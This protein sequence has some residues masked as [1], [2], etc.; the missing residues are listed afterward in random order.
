MTNL[1]TTELILFCICLSALSF[2]LT[3]F[4]RRYA[5]DKRILDIPNNR[6]SHFVP[7]PR[8]GG[9]GFVCTFLGALVVLYLISVIPKEVLFALLGGGVLIAAVGWLDDN[10]GL[11]PVIRLFCHVVAA[12]W[13]VVWLGGYPSMTLGTETLSLS[14]AGGL[15][16][17][18]GTVWMINLYNFMDGIDGI[19]ATEA[20]TVSAI[21]GIILF[22][23]GNGGLAMVCMALAFS[24]VGFLIWNWPPARI[25]MGDVGSGFLGFVFACLAIASENSGALP[26]VV[27]VVLLGV[28]V[29]D[30]TV[31]LIRRFIN[32]EKLYEAHRTHVYQLAVQA[33]FSHKQVT[34]T[35]CLIN[36][37]LG[38][39]AAL[40]AK[41]PGWISPA[42]VLVVVLLTMA[43]VRLYRWFSATLEARE[44]LKV[45]SE[46]ILDE[47]AAST[48]K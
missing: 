29:V 6:S 27:W 35:V 2:G 40:L 44:E 4:V 31:T 34:V 30:A 24:V 36:I 11:T 23:T 25:F 19:A 13:G 41:W 22:V 38:L 26:L 47:A 28:F 37:G 9:L 43:E 45:V 7:T 46:N 32:K 12:V 48:E 15:L 17:V 39:V 33:G 20:V 42:V 14:W 5:I 1:P 8:G 16:A 10:R 18:L 21:A 3:F